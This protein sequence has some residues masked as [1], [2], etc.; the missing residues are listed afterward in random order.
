MDRSKM[1]KNRMD[2]LVS[3][4]SL[5]LAFLTT[6]FFGTY[7]VM[8]TLFGLIGVFHDPS[9]EVIEIFLYGTGGL[10]GI[11]GLWLRAVVQPFVSAPTRLDSLVAIFLICGA[12]AAWGLVMLDIRGNTHPVTHDVTLSFY[13]KGLLSL[14]I[15][16]LGIALHN[17]WPNLSF[18]RAS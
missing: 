11:C 9:L 13:A 1:T 10:L 12:A 2:I 4:V 3:I 16:A 7:A 17:I 5:L 18:K 6:Y 8:G 14:S 15:I